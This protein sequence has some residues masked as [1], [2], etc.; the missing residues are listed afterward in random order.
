MRPRTEQNEAS[1]KNTR[2][3][4]LAAAALWALPATALAQEAEEPTEKGDTATEGEA[5]IGEAAEGAEFDE[6]EFDESEF[7]ESGEEGGTVGDICKIDPAACPTLKMD[8][9]A[10]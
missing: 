1:M 4:L 7:E 3:G 2:I 8:E 5:P 10:A 9:E 6:G